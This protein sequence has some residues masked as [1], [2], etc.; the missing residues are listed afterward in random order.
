VITNL[1]DLIA[2][3]TGL[4][5]MVIGEAMLDCYLEGTASRLCREAPVPIVE[6]TR[7]WDVPG[8]AANTAANLAALGASVTLLSVIGDDPEGFSLRSLLEQRG[9]IG[10]AIIAEPSRETITKHRVRA[11]SQL[12]VRYDQGCTGPMD[13]ASEDLLIDQISALYDH[14]AAV[15][16]SDYGYGVLSPRVLEL[17]ANLQA[18]DPRVLVVDAKDLRRYR[19]MHATAAKPNYEEAIRLLGLPEG[20]GARVRL[21]QIASNG[22]RLLDLIGA[23]LVAVTLDGDGGL[24]LERGA[25]PYRTFARRSRNAQPAGAGDTFVSALALA[26]AAGTRGPQAAELAAAAASVVVDKDGTAVC[27]GQELRE[28]M[29]GGEKCLSD[30]ERLATRV[31]FHREQGKRI[32]FTNGCFD[33]LHGGHITY[34]NR[35][36]ALGDYLI[37]AVNSD[38]SVRRLKGK[39]RPINNLEDRIQVL[40]ALSSVDYIVPFS[41]DTPEDL[42]RL[43]R[44]DIYVKGGDYRRETLP[45][46][47]IIEEQGGTVQILPYMADRSTT[48][49]IERIRGSSGSSARR[50]DRRALPWRRRA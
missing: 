28:C 4:N 48:G 17:L 21:Q 32:V 38:S 31:A 13:P 6:L 23:D 39:D 30:I 19:D 46:A 49:V 14:C 33:I 42:I 3:F 7:R 20:D 43:L 2:S 47:R 25:P 41:A 10:D 44:P 8:G 16:I 45:E 1:P 26:L 15:I 34:L 9:V 22:E 37:V 12:L 18:R 11:D 35:A 24:L 29:A 5:I 50:S 40:A 36:K 27:T